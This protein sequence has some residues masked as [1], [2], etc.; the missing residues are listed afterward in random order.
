MNREE[1]INEMRTVISAVSSI[2]PEEI[3]L[4]AYFI[5]DLQISSFDIIM[6]IGEVEERYNINVPGDVLYKLD[7]LEKVVN[8]IFEV[9]PA[10]Q[11][12]NITQRQV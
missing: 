9:I 4:D 7:N 8:Y 11:R 12:K 3:T 1:V 5:S 2:P 6:I 10:D